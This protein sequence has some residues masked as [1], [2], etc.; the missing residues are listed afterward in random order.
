[1]FVMQPQSRVCHRSD[2]DPLHAGAWSLVMEIRIAHHLQEVRCLLGAKDPA[3][4][5]CLHV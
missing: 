1:M 3:P 2:Q 5:V 4:E